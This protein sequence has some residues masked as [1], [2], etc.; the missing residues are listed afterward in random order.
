MEWAGCKEDFGNTPESKNRSDLSKLNPSGFRFQAMV[1][2]HHFDGFAVISEAGI[3]STFWEHCVE[4]WR[5]CPT[6]G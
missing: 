1:L 5:C 3:A 2:K 6:G 4:A